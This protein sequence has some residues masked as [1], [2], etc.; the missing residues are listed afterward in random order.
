VKASPHV[1]RATGAATS[2][3]FPAAHAVQV[4]EPTPL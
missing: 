1:T 3:N 4:L 2:L